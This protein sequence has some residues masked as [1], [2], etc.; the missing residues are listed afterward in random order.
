MA[1]RFFDMF[2]GIGG[3]RSGLE[4]VGGFECI[5]HCEIDPYPNIAYNAIF[6]TRGEYYCDDARKINPDEMP[7][8]DLVCAGF[9]CQSFSVAGRRLGFEDTRGTLFFEVARLLKAKRPIPEVLSSLRLPDCLRR[10]GLHFFFWKTSSDCY[11]MTK[12]GHLKPSTP[13]LLKWGIVLNGACLTADITFPSSENGCTLS[14]ILMTDVP[15]KYFLS[16]AAMRK[17]SGRLSAA[18]KGSASTTPT[19]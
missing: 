4:A 9:P 6:D 11:R 12:A 15:E 17:I 8:F 16:Q 18:A 5:G 2:S 1:I 7:D 10:N 19:A 13:R 14:D 3:F